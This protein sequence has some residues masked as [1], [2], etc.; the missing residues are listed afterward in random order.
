MTVPTIPTEFNGVP[1]EKL[2]GTVAKLTDDADLARFRF[3]VSNTWIEDT[4][5]QSP[6]SEWNGAG[7]DQFDVQEFADTA[8]HP[9]L[10]HA[11]AV[12]PTA[13]VGTA[14]LP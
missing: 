9:T 14:A 10:G 6:F 7:S 5:A 2:N 3:T 8:D 4:A 1:V 11:V 12:R 13:Q